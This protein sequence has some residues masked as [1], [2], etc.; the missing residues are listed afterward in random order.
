MSHAV[1]PVSLLLG[2]E[3][4]LVE[5]FFAPWSGAILGCHRCPPIQLNRTAQYLSL[6]CHVLW[7]SCLFSLTCLSKYLT[8]QGLYHQPHHH[9]WYV[10]DSRCLGANTSREEH[11]EVFIIELGTFDCTGP[12]TLVWRHEEMRKG[13]LCVAFHPLTFLCVLGGLFSE[14]THCSDWTSVFRGDANMGC[15]VFGLL[16]SWFSYLSAFLLFVCFPSY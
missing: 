13:V 12:L 14:L 6:Y 15:L 8:G 16:L 1:I 4:C 11:H 2:E 3:A 5:C 9:G 7:L 10:L